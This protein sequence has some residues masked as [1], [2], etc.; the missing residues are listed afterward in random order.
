MYDDCGSDTISIIE[1]SL[2]FI[3]VTSFVEKVKS[4][5]QVS[6]FNVIDQLSYEGQDSN[7]TTY[8]NNFNIVKTD[9]INNS[10]KD[11]ESNHKVEKPDVKNR[12]KSHKSAI[13]AYCERF[14]RDNSKT[15]IRVNPGRNGIVIWL[16]GSARQRVYG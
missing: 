14:G 8:L 16:C 4:E 9:F 11:F 6:S 10:S 13:Y 15:S 2:R 7:I 5:V 1:D 12:K 3:P